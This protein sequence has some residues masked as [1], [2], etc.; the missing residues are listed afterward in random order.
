MQTLCPTPC[1]AP[2]ITPCITP[3]IKLLANSTTVS[4]RCLLIF[5]LRHLTSILRSTLTKCSKLVVC[6]HQTYGIWTQFRISLNDFVG[7]S[8]YHLP[9]ALATS[10]P[11]T[12][13]ILTG[14]GVLFALLTP[15]SDPWFPA[16]RNS[17]WTFL[18]EYNAGIHPPTHSRSILHSHLAQNLKLWVESYILPGGFFL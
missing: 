3:C 7:I 5:H 11:Q 12:L 16:V 2:C 10:D 14:A 6:S 15:V 1:I 17:N 4:S 13:A 18:S 9:Q 8:V